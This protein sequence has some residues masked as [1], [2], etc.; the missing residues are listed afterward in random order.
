MQRRHASRARVTTKKRK[1]IDETT[2]AGAQHKASLSG[3]SLGILLSELS[4]TR[5]GMMRIEGETMLE[6]HRTLA[7]RVTQWVLGL[8]VA[9]GTAIVGI[10]WIVPH[11]SAQDIPSHG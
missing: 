3:P 6:E 8:P 11:V 4:A 7:R 9:V 5:P 1:R 2:L 10:N